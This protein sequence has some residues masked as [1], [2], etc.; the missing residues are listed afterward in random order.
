MTKAPTQGSVLQN[1]LRALSSKSAEQ[2]LLQGHAAGELL[3][4]H[5]SPLYVYDA[6]T[7]QRQLRRIRTAFGSDVTVL[8]ALK[9]NPNRELLA[10]LVRAGLQ[11]AD[12]ASAGEVEAASAS[13]LAPGDM[14]FAGPGKTDAE[15]LLAMEMG[16]GCLNLESEQ[17]YEVLADLARASNRR[18]R[19]ALRINPASE[20]KGSRLRMAGGSKKFGIDEDRVEPL[21]RR[22][23]RDNVAELSGLH[24]YAGTQSFD[25]EAWVQ[26]AA[27]LAELA[28]ELEAR[29]SHRLTSLNFGGGF[30]VACHEGDGEFDLEVAG[31]ALRERVVRGNEDRSHYIEPGRCLVAEAGVFLTRVLYTKHS[32]GKDF[33]ILD[34]GMHQHAAAAGLGAVIKR[35]WPVVACDRLRATDLRP[36]TLAGPLCTPQDELGRDV[37][38]PP[39]QRGG[40]PGVP[41]LGCLWRLVQPGWVS[42]PCPGEGSRA[43]LARLVIPERSLPQSHTQTSQGRDLFPVLDTHRRHVDIECQ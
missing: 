21:A 24:V 23:L 20:V 40:H 26:N 9:A 33:A 25:V 29:L 36:V 42:E 28:V 4:Q 19:V 14:H 22:I 8:Y 31:R 13:G 16:L 35:N 17:E 10:S 2:L 37:M 11:G 27:S 7:A 12:V 39:L 43:G 6:G 3:Q 38:L 32:G 15:L 34:G 41:G 5:G 18:P 1:T 30:G